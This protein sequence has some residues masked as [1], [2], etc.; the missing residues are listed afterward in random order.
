MESLLARIRTYGRTSYH[1]DAMEVHY[2]LQTQGDTEVAEHL[3]LAFLRSV[4]EVRVPR[5]L[6]RYLQSEVWENSYRTTF[7]IECPLDRFTTTLVTHVDE[8]GIRILLESGLQGARRDRMAT[9]VHAWVSKHVMTLTTTELLLFCQLVLFLVED[10]AARECILDKT[11]YRDLTERCR[12]GDDIMGAVLQVY[13]KSRVTDFGHCYLMAERAAQNLI[14]DFS[15]VQQLHLHD[16]LVKSLQFL[17]TLSVLMEWHVF[18]SPWVV[19]LSRYG[20]PTAF[21]N[22]V[23][24][25]LS[26]PSVEFIIELHRVHHLDFLIRK[27]HHHVEIS[28]DVQWRVVRGR[29]RALWPTRFASVLNLATIPKD[30]VSTTYECPITLQEC[31]HPVV[32]SD[33]HTYERDALLRFLA[34]H[35][36]PRSPVT[37]T[38]LCLILFENY[39]LYN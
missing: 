23:A 31:I 21:G 16:H 17:E 36:E 28:K 5:D 20:W 37:K 10:E 22:L 2:D 29:L 38:P 7:W 18:L 39:A 4:F 30:A 11:L 26:T 27:A 15:R 34:D 8:F 14:V 12:D 24:N 6:L 33:G 3:T 19:A 25:M 32:A 13:L 1:A 9:N 35:E